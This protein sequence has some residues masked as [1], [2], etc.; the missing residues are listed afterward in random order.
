MKWRTWWWVCFAGMIFFLGSIPLLKGRWRTRDAKRDEAEHEAMVQAE[1]AKLKTTDKGQARAS[2]ARDKP[3]SP[4]IIA[5]AEPTAPAELA[6]APVRSDGAAGAIETGSIATPA[7]AQAS[8]VIVFGQ[9]VVTQ[10]K[11]MSYGVQLSAGPSLD[12]LKLAW[13]K[14]AEKHAGSLAA[15]QPRY[16]KPRNEGG[17][18][19]LLA[20]P[21]PSKA[22]AERVCAEMG[23][24]RN[25]CFATIYMGEPL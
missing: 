21:L 16:V 25:E 24:G 4:H 11:A 2:P 5:V 9:P 3:A 12:G 23:A 1:L 7:P 20:G 6:A 18:Y 8:P 19:R 22:D 13:A 17:P 10:R 14:L 15:L